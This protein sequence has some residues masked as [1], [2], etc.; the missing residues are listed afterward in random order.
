MSTHAPSVVAPVGGGPLT[1]LLCVLSPVGAPSCPLTQPLRVPPRVGVPSYPLTELWRVAPR[2]SVPSCPLTSSV[3]ALLSGC[4]LM[5][6]HTAFVGAP[7]G[8]C[9]LMSPHRAPE[10]SS[11]GQ[12]SPHVPSHL[13]WALSTVGV[14]SRSPCGCFPS[15]GPLTFPHTLWVSLRVPS[16]TRRPMGSWDALGG[17]WPAG[18]GRFSSPSTLP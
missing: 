4:P 12:G 15:E 1:H 13:L 7:T 10:G 11:R 5:S 3:D 2:L 9:P 16:H 17:V 8:G 18:R 6:P 14:P